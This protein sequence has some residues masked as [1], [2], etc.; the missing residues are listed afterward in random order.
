MTDFGLFLAGDVMTGRGIDQVLPHPSAPGL[1]E[2]MVTDARVYVDLAAR[3]NGRI[4]A[5]VSPSYVWGDALAEIERFHPAVRIANLET[6][7][8]T[9]ADPWPG[10]GIHYRMHPANIACLTAAGIGCYALA[11]NHVLDWGRAGLVQTLQTLRQAGIA[12][13]G[14]GN[15]LREALAPAV[16]CLPEQ[17]SN[18]RVLVFARATTSSGVPPAWVAT[19]RRP[20]LA[21]IDHLDEVA[22]RLLAD[23]IRTH[24]RDGDRV[25]L[26]IHWGGNWGFDI[27]SQH[28]DF[29]HRL[30]DLD[31][32]DVVHGHSSHHPLPIEVHRGKLILYGCGD[33]IN[34]YEGIET[35]GALRS[36][37]ACLYFPRLSLSDGTLRRLDI[38][39]V[40]LRRFSLCA[41]D[42]EA[43]RW[44]LEVFDREG[45]RFGTRVEEQA[46]GWR[47]AWT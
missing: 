22:A 16:L 10:K 3:E 13:A 24:R 17:P 46:G 28:R 26:S 37:A 23:E 33:L 38:V 2:P 30:I 40:Q 11:N 32:V 31:A 36:D 7:V 42:L 18:A 29:A 15:D 27:P 35:R 12:V 41:P 19:D 25:V 4:T 34:D 1:F 20:G 9:S 39:P 45:R 6:A 44:L 21:L 14:A 47:L 8:T 43:R 5:P